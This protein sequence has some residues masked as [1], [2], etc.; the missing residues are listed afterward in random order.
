[1]SQQKRKAIRRRKLATQQRSAAA[2]RIA[3]AAIA[4]ALSLASAGS[5]HAATPAICNQSYDPYQVSTATLQA[6]GDVQL[7][8]TITPQADGST[9]YQYTLPGGVDTLTALLPPSSF[10]AATASAQDLAKYGIPA[11]PPL[12]DTVAHGWWQKMIDNLHFVPPA[13][14]LIMGGHK[15]VTYTS[16]YYNQIWSGYEALAHSSNTTAQSAAG[17]FTQPSDG[18][19]CA[20]A[21]ASLW[22]G[23]GE[24]GGVNTDPQLAQDGTNVVWP[25][26]A[27]NQAWIEVLPYGPI[28]VPF[29]ATPGQSFKADV[30][31]SNGQ[32]GY[33]WANF[34]MYNYGTGA[35]YTPMSQSWHR[36]D[37]STADYVLEAPSE[38]DSNGNITKRYP[39]TNI[40]SS[41]YWSLAYANGT[42]IAHTGW[43]IEPDI[44]QNLNYTQTDA[45]TGYL[46]GSNSA[47]ENYKLN[48]N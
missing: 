19:S 21:G 32:N 39:L 22:T 37:L 10:N 33:Q 29:Y 7:P 1:M 18:G 28:N 6:C 48:C 30:S 14:T 42:D 41:A 36:P 15:H 35:A 16:P 12:T 24:G 23:L 20:N 43:P 34:Y 5:A 31:Y 4:G 38:S 47:F 45:S 27:N 8:A 11:E 17:I 9:R 40:G 25:G 3:P 13:K 26:S 2:R 46:Q 44:M